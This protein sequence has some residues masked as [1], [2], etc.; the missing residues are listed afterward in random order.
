MN[1]RCRIEAAELSPDRR[2]LAVSAEVKSMLGFRT[3]HAGMLYSLDRNAIIGR[4]AVVKRDRNGA[5]TNA[6]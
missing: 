3:Q 4:V 5:I 1:G 6:A 2:S